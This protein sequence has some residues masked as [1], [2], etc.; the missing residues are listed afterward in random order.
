VLEA[1][2]SGST[3]RNAEATEAAEEQPISN[4]PAEA[5]HEKAQAESASLLK[6]AW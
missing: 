1:T 5:Y 6:H 2:G 3:K 4:Q